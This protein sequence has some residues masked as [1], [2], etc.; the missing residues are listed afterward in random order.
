M[1]QCQIAKY[2]CDFPRNAGSDLVAGGHNQDQHQ[3][4]ATGELKLSYKQNICNMFIAQTWSQD[5]VIKSTFYSSNKKAK[6]HGK[7]C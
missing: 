3:L 1:H 6:L 2:E 5:R 4:N 7:T